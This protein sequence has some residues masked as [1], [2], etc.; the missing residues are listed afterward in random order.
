MEHARFRELVRSCAS[1]NIVPVHSKTILYINFKK[2]I[3]QLRMIC[4]CNFIVI[5]SFPNELSSNLVQEVKIRSSKTTFLYYL[6]ETR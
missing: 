1:G 6:L 5:L 3:S 2:Y 4:N